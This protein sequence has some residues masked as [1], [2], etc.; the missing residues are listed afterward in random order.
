M[1]DFNTLLFNLTSAQIAEHNIVRNDDGSLDAYVTTIPTEKTCPICGYP[2]IKNGHGRTKSI[3]HSILNSQQLTIHWTPQRFICKSCNESVTE[4]NPFTYPKFSISYSTIRQIMLDLKNPHLSF[5]DVALRNHVS[6]TQV[7][8]YFDSYVHV[9]KRVHLPTNLGIDEIHSDMAKYGSSYLCVLVDND[10]RQL[11]DILPS[12]SKNELIKYFETFSKEERDKVRYVTID[13]WAP[14]RDVAKRVFKYC[15]VAVDP[16]HVVEH[17]IKG[18]SDLRISTMKQVEYGSPSYYLLKKWNWVLTT[19]DVD[20]DNQR[21]MNHVFNRYMNRRDMLNELLAISDDLLVAYNLMKLYQDFN[22]KCPPEE[23]T[24]QMEMIIDSFSK[25][26]LPCYRKF[27][28]MITTWKEEIINSF[29]RPTGRKQSN[30]LTESINSRIRAFL[31]VTRGM[32]NFERFRRRI[33]YCLNDKIFYSC[34]SF[35]TSLKIKSK[36]R[37]PYNK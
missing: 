26:D 15:E 22:D 6:I 14:Y 10:T 24:Q 9:P 17:L 18:F 13:M 23:A 3:T 36:S 29:N 32:C 37:G 34:T 19:K 4:R 21:V 5:K 35:L 20:L 16:F 27:V 30:A 1:V 2:L 28:S 31:A 7:Q 8:K 25:A 12:R 11:F 33:L